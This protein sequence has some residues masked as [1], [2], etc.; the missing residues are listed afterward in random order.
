MFPERTI[1]PD[2]ASVDFLPE[3]FPLAPVTALP[4]KE[5]TKQK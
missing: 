2:K 5:L 4:D 3:M 1:I